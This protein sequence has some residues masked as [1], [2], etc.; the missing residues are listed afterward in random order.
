[1]LLPRTLSKSKTVF[2]RQTVTK[3]P[4]RAS[5]NMVEALRQCGGRNRTQEGVITLV[6]QSIV[7]HLRISDPETRQVHCGPKRFKKVLASEHH[8]NLRASIIAGL[9]TVCNSLSISASSLR[10]SIIKCSRRFSNIGIGK[11][12]TF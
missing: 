6:A 7:S 9:T 11:C 8:L 10:C 4:V 1:M 5:S 12:A 3:P 2:F